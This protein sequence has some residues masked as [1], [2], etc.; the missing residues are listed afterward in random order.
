[1]SLFLFSF[2]ITDN[3]VRANKTITLVVDAA[4]GGHDNGAIGLHGY[5]EKDMVL[6]IAD[7]LEELSKDYNIR[8]VALR[9]EDKYV[10]LQDRAAL[11]NGANAD[12]MISL[13]MN[14]ATDG[15]PAGNEYEFILDERS[16]YFN[17]A[18]LL[19]SA[20]GTKLGAMNIQSDTHTRHLYVLANT[21]VPAITMECGY[22]ANA[23]NV[24]MI[25]N[26]ATLEKLCRAILSSV[27]AY[28]SKS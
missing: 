4:H 28:K 9:K 27:V 26:D 23:T 22:I 17:K 2:R 5:R 3:V 19:S 6:K 18:R 16:P 11:T 20:I 24:D 21:K 8:I 1:G 15:K 13:H 25:Q 10:T 14:S 12:A 7:K